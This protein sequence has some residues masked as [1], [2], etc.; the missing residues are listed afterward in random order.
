[1][2]NNENIHI[3][4][5]SNSQKLTEEICQLL[6]VKQMK[7]V[8]KRFADGEILVQAADSVRGKEIY[9]IQSTSS[10]VNENLM[11][12]LIAIDA[13][14]RASAAK[15]NIVIPY[16]GYSR[17]DRRAGGRQPITAKLVADLLTTAGADRVITV[18]IHSTQSAG[19]FNIPFD[20]FQTSQILA[21]QIAKTIFENHFDPKQSILVSPDHGG[22]NRVHRV[23]SYMKGLTNGVAVI[24]KRRPEPNV[25]EV[26]FVLGDIQGKTCFVIDDMIDTGG[27]IIN[28]A[29]AL[30]ANG[31][32]DVYI[33]ACHGLFNGEAPQRFEAAAKEGIIKEVV[34]TNTIEIPEAKKFSN[35]KIISVAP[36]IANMIQASAD[37]ES[38]THVYEDER[39]TL[40]AYIQQNLGKN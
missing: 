12:L 39:E 4:G 9:V 3:F 1:M 34:V 7:A 24:A 40:A 33:F 6:G 13:F 25:A 20:N 19:F 35:L 27:T 32:K 23:D 36:L 21:T 16:F 10:P 38:L 11:E 31:A 30:K 2:N 5:L 14:R 26:E 17:Q 8:T 15:I 22:L 37:L 28:A 18:D 29:K